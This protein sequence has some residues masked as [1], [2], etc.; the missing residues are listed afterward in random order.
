V[1]IETAVQNKLIFIRNNFNKICYLV[2]VMRLSFPVYTSQWYYRPKCVTQ[3][4]ANKLS[5]LLEVSVF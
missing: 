3:R 2:E 4:M 1:N 5:D